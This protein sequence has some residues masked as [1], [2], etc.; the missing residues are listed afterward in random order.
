MASAA[1]LSAAAT[2]VHADPAFDLFQKFCVETRAGAAQAMAAADASGWMPVPQQMLGSMKLGAEMSGLDG[3][4]TTSRDGLKIVIVAHGK[5]IGRDKD[6]AADICAIASTPPG[7]ADGLKAAAANFARVDPDPAATGQGATGFVWRDGPAGRQRI[8]VDALRANPDP[9]ISA[10]MVQ[11]NESMAMLA[12][13]VP[14]KVNP[15]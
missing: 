3:R 1:L 11:T 10:L 12:F 5:T 13:A 6:I 2:A 7:D 9:T 8:S 4:M 15:N 14:T